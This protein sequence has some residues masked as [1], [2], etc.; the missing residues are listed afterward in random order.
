MGC[1]TKKETVNLNDLIK[2][3]IENSQSR[4]RKSPDF[5]VPLPDTKIA[6]TELSNDDD[7]VTGSQVENIFY[8]VENLSKLCAEGAIGNL[9]NVL[10]CSKQDI[11]LFWSIVTSPVQSIIHALNETHVP[12]AVQ[13]GGIEIDSI[14]KS[15]WIL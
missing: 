1:H 14:E 3:S 7:I 5:F 13:R 12:K 4:E 6:S 8:S 2:Y 15:L 10:H 11:D 9:M